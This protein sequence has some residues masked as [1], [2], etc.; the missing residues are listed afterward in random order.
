MESG[1]EMDF[2]GTERVLKRKVKA[3]SIRKGKKG[4]KTKQV[5]ND[6]ND[7]FAEI[8]KLSKGSNGTTPLEIHQNAQD[9]EEQEEVLFAA[10]RR[11]RSRN[12]LGQHQNSP[13]NEKDLNLGTEDDNQIADDLLSNDNHVSKSDSLF[14]EKHVD[15]EEY[16]DLALKDGYSPT[17]NEEYTN[18]FLRRLEKTQTELLEKK[19]AIRTPLAV[20]RNRRRSLGTPSA[21]S[22]PMSISE[23]WNFYLET[24]PVDFFSS[25]EARFEVSDPLVKGRSGYAGLV[26]NPQNNNDMREMFNIRWKSK[27][28]LGQP[29]GTFEQFRIVVGQYSRFVVAAGLCTA[30]SLCER[31]CL[32][33]V[34]CSYSA[35]QAFI[36]HFDLRAAAGTVMNKAFHL[37]RLC[38]FADAYFGRVHN[39]EKQ[40]NIDVIAEYLQGAQKAFKT[41]SR[42]MATLRKAEE[43][44]IGSGCYLTEQDI[45][46]YGNKAID[47]LHDIVDQFREVHSEKGHGGVVEELAS[48]KGL[49]N[50]WFINFVSALMLHGGGQRPQVYTIL[51]APKKIDLSVLRKSAKET[52][53]FTIKVSCEKRLR[54][55]DLP[56]VLFPRK[57]FKSLNF[58]VN[59]VLPALHMKLNIPEEDPRTRCLL[60]HTKRGEELES[61]NITRSIRTFLKA[62]DPELGNVTSMTLR[63]SFATAM[64]EKHRRGESLAQLSEDEFIEYL[65]KIMNTS[66]EQL[67]ETYIATSGKSYKIC[68]EMM[69]SLL[70]TGGCTEADSDLD[71]F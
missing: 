49:L 15:E 62:F 24:L 63:A 33:R 26:L 20:Q 59:Y 51:Q 17:E 31:G 37:H 41:E 43:T 52:T 7:S 61:S 40:G 68:A 45:Q 10:P 35:I 5:R 64:L 14:D 28:D 53:A 46:L 29:L 69:F 25:A 39:A 18:N 66:S 50:K 56:E 42:K 9:N 44:R 27:A 1:F 30:N 58:H 2:A 22:L 8:N 4:K 16:N 11:A 34:A 67:K 36:R 19:A 3:I 23:A 65:A 38:A 47:I 70:E 57:V 60:L 13:K 71:V 54:A 55:I 6:S 48:T 12:S 21:S 32:Y